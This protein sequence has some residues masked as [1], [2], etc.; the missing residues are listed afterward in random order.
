[1]PS[2]HTHVH[3]HCHCLCHT[4]PL[5][6]P[7]S[8][9]PTPTPTPPRR[10]LLLVS[11]SHLPVILGVEDAEA[12]GA[13]GVDIGVEN[14]G[15]EFDDRG[16]ARVVVAE[17][18]RYLVQTA[19]PARLGEWGSEEAVRKGGALRGEAR[20][21]EDRLARR[22]LVRGGA[23]DMMVDGARERVRGGA[24]SA[25]SHENI[26]CV[27]RTNKSC[28]RRETTVTTVRRGRHADGTGSGAS[29]PRLG[30]RRTGWK[31]TLK[32]EPQSAR[33]RAFQR[34]RGVH[35]DGVCARGGGVAGA[36]GEQWSESRRDTHPCLPRNPAVPLHQI[37][38]PVGL[39]RGARVERRRVVSP[40]RLALLLQAA[41]GDP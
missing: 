23:E 19:R 5:S 29:G 6:L 2:T 28:G 22:E 26:H 17:R 9:P 25:S 35:C 18:D 20:R 36:A 37:G 7:L 8:L 24:V 34:N 41:G 12:D 11:P 4:L 32:P 39:A 33:T 3:V 27:P 13:G 31:G 15:R 38:L 1:M 21:Q 14:D 10:L 40:P 16:F 30:W